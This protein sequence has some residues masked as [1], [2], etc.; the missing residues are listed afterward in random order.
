MEKEFLSSDEEDSLKLLGLNGL[1]AKVYLALLELG[2]AD[3]K[4]VARKTGVARQHVYPVLEELYNRS[5]VKKT[6]AKPTKYEAISLESGLL[7]LW[8]K[9]KK[10]LEELYSQKQ[11]ALRRLLK[12][13]Q[14]FKKKIS[15]LENDAQFKLLANTKEATFSHVMELMEDCTASYDVLTV[16]GTSWSKYGMELVCESMK[17]ATE[18][19]V[20]VRFLFEKQERTLPKVIK[21]LLSNPNIRIKFLKSRPVAPL[22]ITDRNEVCIWTTTHMDSIEV[23]V[24]HYL[25]SN[26]PR[27]V[28]AIHEYFDLLWERALEPDEQ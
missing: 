14:Q 22:T 17:K 13:N 10:F 4:T 2:T 8:E 5:I 19:G 16:L 24:G 6:V 15:T 26:K 12:E 21:D 18:R 27:F 9:Q 7:F 3:A 11:N 25:W 1:Q 28:G 20:H 23:N